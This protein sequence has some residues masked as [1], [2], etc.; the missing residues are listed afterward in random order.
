[1]PGLRYGE[2]T[3]PLGWWAAIMITVVAG[4]VFVCST[5]FAGTFRRY[6]PVSLTADRTGLVL[7]KGA[8]VRMRG[9]DVGRVGAIEGGAAPVRL[10]LEIFPDKLSFIP[11]NVEAEIK[12]TTAFGAKYVE[13]IPPPAPSQARLAAGMT[14]HSRNVATEVNTV[15]QNLVAVLDQI[16]VAKLNATLS[17]LADGV[18]GRGESIGQATT[19][20]SETLR[21]L[22][23]RI[24]SMAQGWRSFKG[25]TDAYGMAAEDILAIL[26]AAATT[27]DTVEARSSQ[28]DAL[29]LSTIGMAN[30]GTELLGSTRDD[31]VTA[32]NEAR[33][34]TDLLLKYDPVYTC[35][36]VGAKLY[37]DKGGYDA[38]GGNGRTLVADTTLLFGDDPY[39]YPEHL[40][41][42]NAKGGPGG[43]PGC[44]SLP[45]VEQNFPVRKLVTD[46]GFGSGT[47]IRTNPGIGHPWFI[48]FFPATRAVPE[49][50]YVLGEGPP[51]PGPSPSIPHGPVAAPVPAPPVG[52]SSPPEPTTDEPTPRTQSGQP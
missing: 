24:D 22:N 6:V 4:M 2:R 36:L 3:L 46:T 16:D 41:I 49:H 28:L 25:F 37:L 35:L 42:H 18:R 17:A 50:P 12:A 21:Q 44:G 34:T 20:V 9:V 32:V 38:L 11:S 48:N 14:V 15:F 29:L 23:V 47:D 7:E 43:K 51:A 52:Q 33:P 31:F 40:P 13:L 45:D 27:A 19:A 8:K 39:R 26:D 5:L 10:E 30:I 1:M